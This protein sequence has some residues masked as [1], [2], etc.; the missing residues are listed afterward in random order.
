M[1]LFDCLVLDEWMKPDWNCL[2]GVKLHYCQ[3]ELMVLLLL[4]LLQGS[5]RAQ[6]VALLQQQARS[7][8]SGCRYLRLESA[9]ALATCVHEALDSQGHRPAMDY[10]AGES[11]L[12]GSW[13]CM[14]G[15][16]FY[17][18]LAISI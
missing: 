18:R 13:G 12:A 17:L 3:Q 10:A 14:A 7:A 15:T 11:S 4:L 5:K 2:R 16:E 1:V 9:A 6:A 8:L